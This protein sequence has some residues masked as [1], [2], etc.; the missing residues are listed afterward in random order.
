[1]DLD[2]VCNLVLEIWNL[3]VIWCLRFG[4]LIKDGGLMSRITDLY[5]REIL[6]SRGNPTVEVDCWL[7]S[8]L[9]GR[10]QVPSGAS[11]GINEA[12]EIRDHDKSRYGGKGVLKAIEN[13]NQ[14]IKKEIIGMDA[15]NQCKIDQ[16][17]I[18]L[19]GTENKSK[20]GANAM[21]GVSL[22][23]AIVS[24]DEL[25]IPLFR[26][27]GGI[28]GRILP[29]PM[30]NLINGGMHADNNLD[31]QE[32]MIVPAGA[33]SFKEAIRI[34]AE[35]FHTLK[36][37]IN[38]KGYSTNVGDEG[39]FAPNLGENRDAIELII[40]AIDISGYKPGEDIYIAIDSAAS[41]FEKGGIYRFEDKDMTT[42]G[43]IEIYEGWCKRYPIISIEDGLSEDDWKG[44]NLL[45]ERLGKRVQIV[46][47]DL[48]VTNT[49][50]LRRGI[51]ER[52]ANSILIKLNQIGTVTETL[53]TIETAK[54]AGF[55]AVVS[56]R[57]GETESVVISHLAVGA[58]TGLIKSGAPSRGERVA[59]YNELIRIEEEM[60][61][62][63]EYPGY[64]A[65]YSIG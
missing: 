20:L 12:L 39:G 38:K 36:K 15:M 13:V 42:E 14:I 55:T 35:I 40:E 32:F 25:E 6:D 57:S 2:I 44:W 5:A 29:V 50:M 4:I 59:K 24:A 27:I 46:G 58:G 10:A 22:A 9:I 47:D 16:S 54:R 60:G 1:M 7:E 53:E 65:F 33:P 34:S 45:T 11:T 56:H 23:C 63:A 30:L 17:L 28:R 19:D 26:Y 51:D 61:D 21:L 62:S 3:F 18:A 37:L 41:S 52:S 8:G 31:I 64:L 43:L 48:F 49:K